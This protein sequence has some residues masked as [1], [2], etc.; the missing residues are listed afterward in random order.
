M[1]VV[2]LVGIFVVPQPKY[3]LSRCFFRN[4]FSIFQTDLVVTAVF[5]PQSTFVT[6]M[7]IFIKQ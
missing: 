2:G 1:V 5:V 6:D 7:H 3:F 4:K